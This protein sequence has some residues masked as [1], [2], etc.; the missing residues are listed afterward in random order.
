MTIHSLKNLRKRKVVDTGSAATIGHVGGFHIDPTGPSVTHVVLKGRGG[1]TI[2]FTDLISVGPD[3]LTVRS[4]D[5]VDEDGSSDLPQLSD[6]LRATLLDDSGTEL[7]RVEDILMDD[8]GHV[9]GV[10]TSGTTHEGTLLG[11]GSY[12]V[13]VRRS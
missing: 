6:G 4:A 9:T 5:V 7:G 8:D 12:A 13:V 1:G 10:T 11:I 3:A 2:A